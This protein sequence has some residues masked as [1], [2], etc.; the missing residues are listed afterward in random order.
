MKF[1][2]G[3][4]NLE[5][6]EQ[7][8]IINDTIPSPFK[9]MMKKEDLTKW[10]LEL[11]KTTISFADLFQF[12]VNV[13]SS[14]TVI[15]FFKKEGLDK[16]NL[17][18]DVYEL[19]SIKVKDIEAAKNKIKSLKE[20]VAKYDPLFVVIVN[21][22]EYGLNEEATKE[23]FNELP[24]V[25]LNPNKLV[26]EEPK[27]KGDKKFKWENPFKI[28]AKNKGYLFFGFLA[29]LLLSFALGAGLYN[30]YLGNYIAALFFF[31]SLSGAVLIFIVYKDLLIKNRFLS[32]STIT[33]SV[34]ILI[35]YLGGFGLYL[36]MK[37]LSVDKPNPAPKTLFVV[38]IPLVIIV[39]SIICAYIY[40]KYIRPKVLKKKAKK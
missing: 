31:L 9:E 18:K 20:V 12:Q 5:Y 24:T 7:F 19:K 8:N 32:M 21:K 2:N 37:K 36:L 13:K 38:A 22:H 10:S 39:V 4:I 15:F 17:I 14:N 3:D 23:L 6:L 34:I 11:N 25:Y 1:I 26:L 33:Y 30:A 16:E 27:D 40:V 28:I 29:S 35:G